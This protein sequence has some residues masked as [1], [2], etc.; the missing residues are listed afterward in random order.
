MAMLAVVVVLLLITGSSASF[1]WFMNQQQTRVGAQYRSTVAMAV[2]EAGV[3]RALSILEA[4]GLHRASGDRAWRPA[5]YAE[6]VQVGST[7]GRFTLSLTDDSSGAIVITSVGEA[8]G[9]AR[10]LRAR[11]HLAAP[12]LLAG[13]HGAGFVRLEKP[14]A[15]TAILPYGAGIGDRPWVHIAAGRGIWFA[16]TD[17]SIND[18]FVALDAG[19]GPVD[20]PAG[21]N[22]A[23]SP[24]RPGPVRLLLARGA[25]LTLGHDQQR[26]DVQQLRVMG[27]H[28]DGAVLRSDV[29]PE[30]PEVDR[31]FFQAQAAGN[32]GNA[33]L[34][35][36]AGNYL[37]DSDLARKRDSLYAPREFEALQVYLKTGRH[38]PRFYG[39]IYISGLMSLL[40]GERMHVVDGAL[41][42]ES[43]VHLGPGASLDITHSAATRTLP[44][45][46]AL[47]N[48]SLV[49]GQGA[50]LR[51]HGLMFINRAIDVRE[52]AHVAIVGA[53]LGND[54]G[55]SFRSVAA[56]V[57]IRYDPAVLGT[58]GLRLS[59]D[60]PVV[61][62]IAAWQELP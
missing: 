25:E 52:G 59:P 28:V 44:G 24:P 49:V 50:R 6:S 57:I 60:A 45:L 38:A 13:L 23:T 26:V 14:P 46:I 32:T 31:A 48:G 7:E 4:M 40:D 33:D 56:T 30:L 34:N 2:A 35:E 47:D 8:A 12:A 41:I 55:L 51:M 16:T 42:T 58:P 18:P 22:S 10:R 54:P 61:A 20:A 17:V 53:V 37:G 36:A 5:A 15:A 29:L 11:I 62:W 21:A 1:I 43:T 39:V 27:V 19:A 3:H 9:V